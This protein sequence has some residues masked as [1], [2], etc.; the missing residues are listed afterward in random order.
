M[1]LPNPTDTEMERLWQ[2]VELVRALDQDVAKSHELP[3]QALSCLAYIASHNNCN[4]QDMEVE[5]G[6]SR[7]SGSRNTDWLSRTHRLNKSGLNLIKKEI[8]PTDKRKTILSLTR[9]GKDLVHKIAA[10]LY[11]D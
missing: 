1:I 9:Q 8:D 3:I 7:A 10:I 2:V 11:D 5:L 4:K 6:M